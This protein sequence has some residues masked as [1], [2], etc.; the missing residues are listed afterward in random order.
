MIRRMHPNRGKIT[1]LDVDKDVTLFYVDV[2][3]EMDTNIHGRMAES[4][5][6][7]YNLDLQHSEKV[8]SMQDTDEAEP[9]EVEEVLE[10]VT[11]AKL[12]TEEKNGCVIQ[13][14]EEIAAASVIVHSKFQSKDRG[15]GIL[16]EEP[17]P[18][19][20]QAQINI[21]EAFT[22]QLEAELNAN[23]NWNDVIKQLKRK[24]EE[25]EVTV[26]EKRQGGNLKE[27]LETLW[28]LVKERFESIEP[29]NFSNDF[30]L[31][32][33]KI[34]FEKPNVEANVWRDQ[35]GRY[36][37]AKQMLDNL[38]LEV[39]E[40][41]E[42][43]LELLRRNKTLIKAARTMLA[44][45]KLPI[46][47]WD[48]AVNTACYVKHRRMNKAVKVVVQIQSDHLRDEAQR[49][50]DEFL[51]TVDEKMQKI[52]KEQV[53]KRRREGKEPQSVSAPLE[54]AT[55]STGRSTQGSQSQLTSASESAFT[56]E[57]M[58]ITCQMEEP[59]HPEFNTCAEDQPIVQSS[60][61][62]EWFSQQQ[63]SPSLLSDSRSFFNEL[64]DTH[65]DCS[66]PLINRLKVDTLTSELLVGPT[67]ELMK[68]LCKS[69]VQLE[70]HLEEVFKATTDQLDWVNPEGQQYPH[71]LLKPL[72]LIP[73]KRGHHVIPFEHFINND[74]EYL[75]GGASS[76]KYTTSITK[77]KAAD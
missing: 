23:I 43:S 1:K 67:Y 44:D 63:K 24:K 9:A 46:T 40:E 3:V 20:G 31:N 41:S 75:Y 18:L 21:D 71:N 35:K 28:K 37:L 50:N 64:M 77:T 59:S 12:M 45:S 38:R 26:Q 58:Q 76:R 25:E 11:V 69:L 5:A 7:A 13:D 57:P 32:S 34:M 8:L 29:K 2:E 73:N 42:M 54:T 36:R 56:K 16:I 61:H 53:S 70:Y 10:V 30:L 51:K 49:E 65:L 60:Q 74:L 22:R 66:N 39:E 47:F 27:D 17:K 6:K 62:S 68:G 33:L 55:R 15:K 4:Q 14:P 48:E 19:K 72:P 52:I